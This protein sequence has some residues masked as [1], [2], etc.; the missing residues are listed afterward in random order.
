MRS[1][2]FIRYIISYALVLILPFLSLYSFL[3]GR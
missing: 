2:T 3:T 1:K